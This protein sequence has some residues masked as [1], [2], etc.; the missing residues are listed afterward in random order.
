MENNEFGIEILTEREFKKKYSSLLSKEDLSRFDGFRSH[1]HR[2][3][4]NEKANY[5][6]SISLRRRIVLFFS[7]R[8]NISIDELSAESRLLWETYRNGVAA[9]DSL[10][11]FNECEREITRIDRVICD[12]AA[13]LKKLQF[14]KEEHEKKYQKSIEEELEENELLEIVSNYNSL[15]DKEREELKLRLSNDYGERAAEYISQVQG[16][17][18]FVD[19]IMTAREKREVLKGAVQTDAILLKTRI[20]EFSQ[21][22]KKQQ[23]KLRLI[24]RRANEFY[25]IY[26]AKHK[27]Y[28]KGLAVVDAYFDFNIES[29]SGNLTDIGTMLADRFYEEKNETIESD[30]D[31]LKRHVEVRREVSGL[32]DDDDNDEENA[33]YNRFH[34]LKRLFEEEKDGNIKNT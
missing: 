22:V 30:I 34:I 20:E 23:C 32:F 19:R 9:L 1:T 8:N 13:M 26:I 6:K 3:I 2:V 4:E 24:Q 17:K 15:S 27:D 16:R 5:V 12:H 10:L 11:S 21:K 18:I 14:E 29:Y 31:L 33:Q 28:A 7:G 25:E